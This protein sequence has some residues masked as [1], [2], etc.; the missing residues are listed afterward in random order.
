MRTRVRGNEEHC[1]SLSPTSE[2]IDITRFLDRQRSTSSVLSDVTTP[3]STTDEEMSIDSPVGFFRPGRIRLNSE[4]ESSLT[5]EVM[6]ANSSLLWF[7]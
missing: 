7:S 5:A 2:K 6:S 1:L 3:E 4:S